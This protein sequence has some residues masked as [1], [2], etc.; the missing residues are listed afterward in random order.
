MTGYTHKDLLDPQIAAR[1]RSLTR[2]AVRYERP[3][4]PR[5]S[6]ASAINARHAHPTRAE[7]VAAVGVVLTALL[8][9]F[10]VLVLQ[11]GPATSQVLAPGAD[12]SIVVDG[13]GGGG[14]APRAL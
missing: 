1:N 3:E 6:A 7:V 11:A 13:Q 4:R 12:N 14:T 9:V 10:V 8:A 2:N 5:R